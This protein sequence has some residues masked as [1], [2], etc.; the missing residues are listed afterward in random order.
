MCRRLRRGK[1]RVPL[2][3][4]HSLLRQFQGS[5]RKVVFFFVFASLVCMV[6]VLSQGLVVEKQQSEAIVTFKSK[7]N[8]IGEWAVRV[9]TLQLVVWARGA[10]CIACDVCA[11]GGMA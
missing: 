9:A 10:F 8:N 4:V 6:G 3:D 7:L 1:S 2:T 5:K 11:C